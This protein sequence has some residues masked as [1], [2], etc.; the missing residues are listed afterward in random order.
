MTGSRSD[1]HAWG[2]S[3]NIEIYRTVL[4]IDSDAPGF[5]RA[6]IEPHLSG[7]KA[8]KKGNLHIGGV[9]P[10]PS[11]EISVDYKIDKKGMLHVSIILPEG[12]AGSF[13][14][15]GKKTDLAEGRN[16]FTID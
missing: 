13:I 3:P 15:K 4:G 10:S 14:W 7:L 9:V 2:A 16:D 1:C 11:G 12:M 8:D 6:R 5:R